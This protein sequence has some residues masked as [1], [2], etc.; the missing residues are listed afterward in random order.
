MNSRTIVSAELPELERALVGA[1]LNHARE[2][3]FLRQHV[4]P[5]DITNKRL[6]AI[7]EA[8]YALEPTG[9]MET[10][11]PTAELVLDLLNR[12]GAKMSTADLAKVAEGA[13]WPGTHLNRVLAT[14]K[15]IRD[16]RRK[17][18]LLEELA[19]RARRGEAV[20]LADLEGVHRE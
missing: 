3:A 14:W 12:D 16:G 9:L 13:A 11:A 2:A 10:P 15:A 5:R 6:R 20:S 1:A 8:V 4:H 7:L 18:K 19:E 17:A